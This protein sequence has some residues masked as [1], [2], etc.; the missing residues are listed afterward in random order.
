MASDINRPITDGLDMVAA[1]A[2]IEARIQL[3]DVVVAGPESDAD[4]PRR[5]T[6]MVGGLTTY[7]GN[8]VAKYKVEEGEVYPSHDGGFYSRLP[9][10]SEVQPRPEESNEQ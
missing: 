6:M 7:W 4:S 2:L 5:C 8:P 1:R 9:S 3:M 10:I